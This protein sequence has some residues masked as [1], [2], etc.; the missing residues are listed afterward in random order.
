MPTWYEVLGAPETAGHDALRRAYRA[1]ARSCHP[2]AHATSSSVDQVRAE[3][4]MQELNAAWSVLGNPES[5]TIYDERLAAD[6]RTIAERLRAA[7]DHPVRMPGAG[8]EVG[9]DDDD[10]G[11]EADWRDDDDEWVG[12][13]VMSVPRWV[14]RGIIGVI[15]LVIVGLVVVSAHAGPQP[16]ATYDRTIEPLSDGVSPVGRCLVIDSSRVGVVD[17]S[18]R[19]TGV[20]RATVDQSLGAVCPVGTRSVTVPDYA[21]T[22]CV[23]GRGS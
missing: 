2:D 19:D 7:N 18:D 3:R 8:P 12:S 11:L 5:R 21:R 4:S 13:G 22:L 14:H 6:R 10:D 9:W 23:G 15:A 17:C 1:Q 20:I 16:I